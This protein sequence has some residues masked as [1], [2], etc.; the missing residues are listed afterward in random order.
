MMTKQC[1]HPLKVKM[2]P[3]R[4]GRGTRT[5]NTVV[6]SGQITVSICHLELMY[7]RLGPD[8]HVTISTG[9][10]PSAIGLSLYGHTGL[11]MQA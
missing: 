2:A 8:Y 6:I 7:Q 1:S 3:L 11:Q 9:E 10:K 4:E 5:I